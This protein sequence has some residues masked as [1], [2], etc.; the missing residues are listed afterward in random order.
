MSDMEPL[1]RVCPYC[2]GDLEI[3]RLRCKGCG[4][5]IE[6]SISIPRL[7][8][9]P[10]EDRE[11]IELFVRSS[12]SLKAVAAKLGISYP[13]VRNRLN[14]VIQH[15]EDEQERERDSRRAILDAIESGDI[16]VDEAIQRLREL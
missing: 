13:T 4:I 7:A 10:V 3:E 11:F 5:A 8:R 12:G 15:L 6:G 9:L 2:S 14:K 1:N 16:S